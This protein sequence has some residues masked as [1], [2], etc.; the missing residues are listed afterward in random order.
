MISVR[1]PDRWFIPLHKLKVLNYLTPRGV[2]M[3]RRFVVASLLLAFLS[4]AAVAPVHAASNNRAGGELIVGLRQE[5]GNLDPHLATSFSSFRVIEVMYEGL[6]RYD[7][8]GAIEPALA[9]DWDISED[10]KTYTF[11]LRE[12]V[13]FHDGT[14][15]TAEDVKA[16]F[17][18][19]LD[20]EVGSPQASR[21]QKIESMDVQDEYTISIAL[22]TKFAP[23]LNNVAGPGRAIIPKSIVEEGQSLKKK[24]AGTG[25]FYLEDWVP[26]EQILL[27]KN[28]SYW[29]EG[30][31]YLNGV[32]YKI[33][34]EPATRRAALQSG[35]IHVIP[36]ATSTSVQVLKN[37]KKLEILS[38]QELAYSLIGFNTNK[39]P[40]NDPKV[41][42]AVSY[43][44][45]RNEIIQAVY[46]G[47][48]T[49]GTPLP[50]AL[51]EWY[52]PE[53][54]LV[55]YG[56]DIERAKE[57]LSE[58]GYSDGVSFSITVSPTLDTALQIAQVVQQQVKPAGISIELNTV[59]WGTFLDAWRNSNFD[60][61][62]SLNGGSF[63]PDGYYYRT[64]HSGGSTNVFNYSNSEVDE[65]LEKGR[66][67]TDLAERQKIYDQVQRQLTEQ[68]PILFVA[69]ADLHTVVRDNV[70]GFSQLPD[71]SMAL[72][73]TTWL[74]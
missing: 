38:T 47:L 56:H 49:V 57:L 21:L 51:E 23:F 24:V 35:D 63:D 62:A 7:E 32:S 68:M 46:N 17:N 70:N 59:E 10:G 40:L 42:K 54:E 43:A 28:E 74:S 72:L 73:R 6:L 27:K 18:R 8:N 4:V 48:A 55:G 71:R 53:E 33:I 36:S 37:T 11:H 16:S 29:M 31:P 69:Y 41:R 52:L 67:T 64:F 45:D 15:V 25:P 26:G 14:E 5:I 22:S 58:A 2:K 19:I 65:L 1:M 50:P 30:L 9:K 13:K 66:V 34:P 20:P 61:F 44:L 3:K 12:G 60:A 39:E